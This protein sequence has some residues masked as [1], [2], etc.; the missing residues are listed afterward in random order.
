MRLT[1]LFTL[2]NAYAMSSVHCYVGCTFVKNG[3]T[4]KA[5]TRQHLNSDSPVNGNYHGCP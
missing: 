5:F 3:K 1:V 4:S 2:L